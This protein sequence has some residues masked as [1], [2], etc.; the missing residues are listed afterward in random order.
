MGWSSSTTRP[1]PRR[2][3]S[4]RRDVAGNERMAEGRRMLGAALFARPEE[5]ELSV[6]RTPVHM[7]CQECG[8]G[9]AERYEVLRVTG[10]KRVTRCPECLA[11]LESEDAPTPF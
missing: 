4:R 9:R 3:T 2:W 10:W 5:L 7:V 1:T 11:I 8:C 6:A